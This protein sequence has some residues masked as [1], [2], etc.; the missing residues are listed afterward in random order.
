M[1]YGN[2]PPRYAKKRDANEQEIVRA[3]RQ[4]GVDVYLLDRPLDLLIEFRGEW[5]VMEVKTE[6]GTMTQDQKDLFA[7]TKAPTYLVRG[8]GEAL[9]VLAQ[10]RKARERGNE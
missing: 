5:I 7:R 3:L 4:M 2:G 10:R 6:E 1:G 9:D 8:V